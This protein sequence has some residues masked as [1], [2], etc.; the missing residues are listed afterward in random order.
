[1][2]ELIRVREKISNDLVFGGDQDQR[3][4]QLKRKYLYN[5]FMLEVWME[6]EQ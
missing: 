6:V 2:V 3:A 4:N 1:M 5:T